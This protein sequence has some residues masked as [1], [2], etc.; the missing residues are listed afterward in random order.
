[1]GMTLVNTVIHSHET[2][3]SILAEA[4]ALR[5]ALTNHGGPPCRRSHSASVDDYQTAEML[6]S[7]LPQSPRGPDNV[8]QRP[9]IHIPPTVTPK[10]GSRHA[11]TSPMSAVAV[12]RLTEEDI[13]KAL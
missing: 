8:L 5:A 3:I 9:T 4:H 12:S 1:M 7:C 6:R 11:V 2:P 10:N 13:E